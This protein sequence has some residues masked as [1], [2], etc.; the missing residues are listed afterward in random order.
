[1][2]VKE[3]HGRL[4]RQHQQLQ[5]EHQDLVCERLRLN[6]QVCLEEGGREGGRQSINT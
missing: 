2:T 4:Q 1:M 5:R 6:K 3:D